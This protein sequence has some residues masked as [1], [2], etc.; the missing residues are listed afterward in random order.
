MES[1]A[2]VEVGDGNLAKSCYQ[3]IP[4]RTPMVGGACL[5]CGFS[6]HL[7]ALDLTNKSR[8]GGMVIYEH[9]DSPRTHDPDYVSL[10]RFCNALESALLIQLTL[11]MSITFEFPPVSTGCPTTPDTQIFG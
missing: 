8:L 5:L 11:E 9:F 1:R 3:L 7:L 2:S 6:G 4:C 10:P